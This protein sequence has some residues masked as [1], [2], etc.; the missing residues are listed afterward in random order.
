MKNDENEVE[1]TATDSSK[2]LIKNDTNSSGYLGKDVSSNSIFRCRSFVIAP[3]AIVGLMICTVLMLLLTNRNLDSS[4]TAKDTTFDEHMYIK[5]AFLT[6]F[7]QNLQAEG[8]AVILRSGNK[9]YHVLESS[10]TRQFNLYDVNDAGKHR[11]F[12]PIAFYFSMD[13]L[14]ELSELA[15]DKS[16]NYVIC[17]YAKETVDHYHLI[18]D[19]TGNICSPINIRPSLQQNSIKFC[20]N[21]VYL[22]IVQYDS[23][24]ARKNKSLTKWIIQVSYSEQGNST[25]SNVVYQLEMPEDRAIDQLELNCEPTHVEVYVLFERLLLKYDVF[26]PHEDASSL[27]AN[28]K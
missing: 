18:G 25:E 6:T 11:Q 10:P 2:S 14:E 5:N 15:V 1:M 22:A 17:V 9:R 16:G 13:T 21:P 28:N 23:T 27:L 8:A 26:L 3:Y 4:I 24:S 20:A 19:E 7:W 12:T